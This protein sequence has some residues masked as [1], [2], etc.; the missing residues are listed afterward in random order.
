MRR[1]SLGTELVVNPKFL[2]LDEI[3]SGLDSYNTLNVMEVL[4]DVVANQG[5]TILMTIHQPSTEA[6]NLIDNVILLYSV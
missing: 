4:Q 2:F 5:T 3:T 1:V 6:F